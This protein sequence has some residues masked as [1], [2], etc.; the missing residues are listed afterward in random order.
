MRPHRSVYVIGGAHSPYTGRGRPEFVSS[1]HPDHGHRANPTLEQHLAVAV[2][3]AL[4]ACGADAGAIER[5]YVAN[6]L[7]ELFVR[8]GHLGAALAGAVPGL[9]G[10][11]MAR[12]EAACASGGAA[13]TACVDALA[14]GYDV[15]LCAGVEVETTVRGRDGVDFMARA[16]SHQ[17][18]E[19]WGAPVFPWLFARR[20]RQYKE[21]WGAT[22]L[23][24][25]R[26]VVKA[27]ANA[28]RNPDAQMRTVAMPL[29]AAMVRDE[30][31]FFLAD[32]AYREHIVYA[33]CTQFSDGASAVVLA[34]DEG[35]RRL[36]VEREQC[37]ELLAYGH[38]VAPLDAD[39]D[40]VRMSNLERAAAVAY[41]DAGVSPAEIDVAEVHDCFSV[42]ELQAMEAVGFCP[43]GGAPAMLAAGETGLEGRLPINPGGGLLGFGHPV[44]ATGVKQV[45]EI[46]RQLQ[47]RA[48]DY[49]VAGAPEV[50]LAAN[51]GGDD[52]TGVVTIQRRC[53]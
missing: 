52:R 22:D 20:A 11:P 46:W 25:A 38:T 37:T 14:G 34:S 2:R 24:L 16:A 32:P 33:D 39:S 7:G 30:S 41:R 10:K 9:D 1:G 49:Q 18:A 28:S 48:G 47:G 17:R 8:Q 35:L 23:D 51:L 19:G 43:L 29:E 4:A 50:G 45:V 27:Y 5:A 6:F 42:A 44:G 36:G 40:P 31:T 26:V 3:G 12:I 13:I 15:A 21:A 53:G